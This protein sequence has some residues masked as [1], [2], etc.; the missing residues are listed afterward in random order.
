VPPGPAVHRHSR[1]F[2]AV[3]SAALLLPLLAGCVEQADPEVN[4][5][6]FTK[7][8]ALYGFT[9][10]DDGPWLASYGANHSITI[11]K[12]SDHN[13][14][15]ATLQLES[16]DPHCV[17][18]DRR[19]DS[20]LTGYIDGRVVLWQRTEPSGEKWSFRPVV[21]GEH[22]EQLSCCDLSPDG[23]T[24]VTGDV[25]GRVMLWDR[26]EGWK[27][28]LIRK[29]PG[30]I[31]A[32]CLSDD[33][34]YILSAGVGGVVSVW[35]TREDVEE[36]RL[37]GHDGAIYTLCISPTG[38]K[39]LSGGEDGTVCLWNLA[40]GREIWRVELGNKLKRARHGIYCARI[41]PDGR[42]AALS[43]FFSGNITLMSVHTQQ[44]LGTLPAHSRMIT[45][46]EF[47][48]DGTLYSSSHDGTVQRH[49]VRGWESS[50]ND[51]RSASTEQLPEGT[52]PVST[53]NAL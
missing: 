5:S 34:R 7:R 41:S 50:S 47:S 22:S 27:P 44:I 24:A 26:R 8:E 49:D 42:L 25:K 40:D 39:A 46:L 28:R 52:A 33:G 51:P 16:G 45:H 9:L 14:V 23:Q 10:T 3:L 18:G 6:S 21:L 38:H 31:R 17:A 43:T 29:A 12:Q 36:H 2:P 35:N 53:S 20:L 48:K 15:L 32:V 13:R 19:G 4:Q 11:R 37:T 30:A 1:R